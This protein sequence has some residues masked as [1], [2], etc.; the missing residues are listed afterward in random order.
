MRVHDIALMFSGIGARV[1]RDVICYGICAICAV[2]AQVLV[3]WALVLV[4]LPVV[5]EVYAPLIVAAIFVLIIT[6]IVLWLQIAH[7]RR[8]ATVAM[9]LAFGAQDNVQRQAQFVQIAMIVEAMLIG[10]ALSRRR[11]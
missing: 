10:Y 5:G 11:R 4:L 9:P 7:S 3:I 6:L 1:R 2:S 8:R